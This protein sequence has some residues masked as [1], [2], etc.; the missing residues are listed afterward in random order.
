MIVETNRLMHYSLRAVVHKGVEGG[1][2]EG[3]GG[4]YPQDLAMFRDTVGCHIRGVLLSD[5]G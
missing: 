5:S 3:R 1:M 4:I 2:G